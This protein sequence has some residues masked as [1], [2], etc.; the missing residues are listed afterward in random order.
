MRELQIRLAVAERDNKK[1]AEAL[2]AEKMIKLEL[3]EKSD[4]LNSQL[5]QQRQLLLES[6]RRCLS[7]RL[8][9]LCLVCLVYVV[10]SVQ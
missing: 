10:I 7:F 4:D 1:L 3:S 6:Q 8:Y 9:Y 2:L 5:S